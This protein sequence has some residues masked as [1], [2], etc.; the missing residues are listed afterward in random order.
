M[1]TPDLD[2]EE[3]PTL[4][5]TASKVPIEKAPTPNVPFIEVSTLGSL[6][7]GTGTPAPGEGVPVAE[8]GALGGKGRVRVG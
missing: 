8:E 3:T 1:K 7:E 4:E 6:P 2:E 5:V